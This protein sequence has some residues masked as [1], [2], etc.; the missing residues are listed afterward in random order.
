MAAVSCFCSTVKPR[1]LTMM[2]VLV[3]ADSLANPERVQ[4][5]VHYASKSEHWSTCM[6]SLGR[7]IWWNTYDIFSTRKS[8]LTQRNLQISNNRNNYLSSCSHLNRYLNQHWGI[9]WWFMNGRFS[10]IS[11]HRAWGLTLII[12][13]TTCEYNIIIA[14]CCMSVCAGKVLQF[15]ILT[16]WNLSNLFNGIF[17]DWLDSLT[18]NLWDNCNDG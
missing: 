15:H 16:L 6:S 1:L 3:A 12:M 8:F 2:R 17:T 9:V 5:N 10:I 18:H 4:Y 7:S 11:T 13:W 14:N